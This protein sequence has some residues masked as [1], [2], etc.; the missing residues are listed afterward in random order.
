MY[1]QVTFQQLAKRLGLDSGNVRVKQSDRDLY[2]VNKL[3]VTI[4]GTTGIG[5]RF[6][7]LTHELGHMLDFADRGRFS[8][9]MLNDFGFKQTG[10][11]NPPKLS[12]QVAGTENELRALAFQ[13]KLWKMYKK[14]DEGDM[15]LAIN[16][17]ISSFPTE[18]SHGFEEFERTNDTHAVVWM[19]ALSEE[20]SDERV[21]T[22]WKAIVTYIES[23]Y[24]KSHTKQAA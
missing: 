23:E 3:T 1:S 14:F 19:H 20:I 21:R 11:K 7:S 2:K 13:L 5:S 16:S 22:N 18:H 12:S 4:P 17:I 9:I 15:D 6:E 24:N 10:N 8:K